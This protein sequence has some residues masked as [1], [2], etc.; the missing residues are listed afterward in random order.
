MKTFRSSHRCSIIGAEPLISDTNAFV[1]AAEA[2]M[3]EQDKT[4]AGFITVYRNAHG[5]YTAL[6]LYA[7]RKQ[8]LQ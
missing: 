8:R 7:I 5:N 1:L 6:V 4:T 2:E 3:A